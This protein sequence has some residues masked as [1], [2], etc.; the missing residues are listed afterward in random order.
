MVSPSYA[1]DLRLMQISGVRE[2]LREP[3]D[4]APALG[5]AAADGSELTVVMVMDL[6]LRAQG[7][8]PGIAGP[9]F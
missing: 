5:L 8:A 6:P 3:C 1:G 9:M 4:T 7:E 2:T